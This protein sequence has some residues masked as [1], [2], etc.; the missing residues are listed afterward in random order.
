MELHSEPLERQNVG[1]VIEPHCRTLEFIIEQVMG[2]YIKPH[3][4][5]L[6]KRK[7]QESRHFKMAVQKSGG[8]VF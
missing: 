7:L 1:P 3:S 2:L 6:E 8:K 5:H 4:R